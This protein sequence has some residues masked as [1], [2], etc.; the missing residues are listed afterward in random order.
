MDLKPRLQPRQ[1]LVVKLQ[2]ELDEC[3][4]KVARHRKELDRLNQEIARLT[5]AIADAQNG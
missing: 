3:R 2:A 5:Q 1:E 4:A